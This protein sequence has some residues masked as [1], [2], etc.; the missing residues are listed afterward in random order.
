MKK[1]AARFIFLVVLSAF[2]SSVKAGT[3]EEDVG[4]G[5]M[6]R[7]SFSSSFET[8][9]GETCEQCSFCQG[10]NL[11]S[12]FDPKVESTCISCPGSEHS[13]NSIR[14]LTSFET[15]HMMKFLQMSSSGMDADTDPVK[16][17]LE[18]SNDLNT[19][20]SL[21]EDDLTFA[22]RKVAQ[23]FVLSNTNEYLHYSITF[24]RNPA[25]TTMHIGQYGVIESYTKQC[26]SNLYAAITGVNIS[27]YKTSAPTDAP[28]ESPS[29][30]PTNT[31]DAPTDSPSDSPTNNPTVPA[32]ARDSFVY[33]NPNESR[34]NGYYGNCLHWV[35][36]SSKDLMNIE[37]CAE[38]CLANDFTGGNGNLDQHKEDIYCDA[39]ELCIPSLWTKLV[40]APVT[41]RTLRI[42]GNSVPIGE[43]GMPTITM[44]GQV[45]GL[46]ERQTLIMHDE[47]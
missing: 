22:T 34:K 41:Y 5:C 28:T 19:W 30:S 43:A 10:F 23:D 11:H 13:C 8:D 46:S 40:W 1:A 36:G 37:E 32:S 9:E 4:D 31:T 38:R 45:L 20:S 39:F 16:I 2:D 21:Y 42:T 15:A 18:G 47:Y 33:G 35:K 3:I 26:A 25:S 6:N 14:V 12:I 24:E 27:P 7:V 44:L 29:D 17:T